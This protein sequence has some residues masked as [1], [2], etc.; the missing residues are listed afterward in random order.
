MLLREYLLKIQELDDDIPEEKAQLDAMGYN[1]H[2]KDSGY[3]SWFRRYDQIP[4][5]SHLE[6]F[7][8]IVYPFEWAAEQARKAIRPPPQLELF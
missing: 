5:D 2:D 1:K 4:N 3:R 8:E 6:V 7:S